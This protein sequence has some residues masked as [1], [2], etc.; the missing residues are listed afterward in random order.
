MSSI[1]KPMLITSWVLQVVVAFILGQT[2][3][4]KFTGAPETVAMFEVL[5]AEPMGRIGSGVLELIAVVLLLIPRTSAIGAVVSLGVI[6]G[7]I[8]AHLTKL[9]ISIDPVALG[10]PALEPL[11]GASLFGMAIVVFVSSVAIVVIRRGQL[12]VVGGMLSSG[13]DALPQGEV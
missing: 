10:N 6:T 1:K 11:E 4:F 9:G 2:L 8:G 5:G 13:K 12:P 3:F 7:A